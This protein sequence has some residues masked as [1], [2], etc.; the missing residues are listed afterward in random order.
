MKNFVRGLRRDIRRMIDSLEYADVGEMLSP[1][2]K[3]RILAQVSRD[4]GR[5]ANARS[6]AGSSQDSKSK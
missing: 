5:V 6:P 2:S 4:R 3:A 1:S